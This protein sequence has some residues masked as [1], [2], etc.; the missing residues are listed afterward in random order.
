LFQ[1]RQSGGGGDVGGWGQ[2]QDRGSR[3]QLGGGGRPRFG[4]GGGLSDEIT[5]SVPA[6]KCGLVIGKGW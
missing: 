6:D 3:E 2:L 1:Q 5:Y 4:N